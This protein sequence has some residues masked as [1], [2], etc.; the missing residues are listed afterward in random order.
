[1]RDPGCERRGRH[2]RRVGHGRVQPARVGLEV[3]APRD[4][5]VRGGASDR[6]APLAPIDAG[7]SDRSPW[8]ASWPEPR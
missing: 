2:P 1:M 4:R 6:S 5:L 7:G 8:L 3:F